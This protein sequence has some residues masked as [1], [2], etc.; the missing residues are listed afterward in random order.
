LGSRELEC[1]S[2]IEYSIETGDARP[3][4]NSPHRIPHALKPVVDKYIDDM[5]K[6]KLLNQVVLLGV[7]A[8]C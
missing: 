3:I 7:V 2:Q 6:R 4:K 5:L 1:T 8:L